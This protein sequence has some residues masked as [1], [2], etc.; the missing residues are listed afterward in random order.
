MR[1]LIDRHPLATTR[2]FSRG[3]LVTAAFAF[4]LTP[5]VAF[6]QLAH[7]QPGGLG[8]YSIG[9]IEMPLGATGGNGVYSWQVVSGT[10]PPGVSLRTDVVPGFAPNQQGELVGIATTPGTYDFTLRV[11]SATEAADQDYTLTISS[12]VAKD[13]Y[14]LP[15]GFA[16]QPYSYALTAIRDGAAVPATWALIGGGVPGLTLTP[17]GTL[18]GRP[19]AAGS[20]T[21]FFSLT[22]GPDRVWRWTNV[23]VNQIGIVTD[24]ALPNATPGT[25][26][27]AIVAASGGSGS[28]RFAANGS[29]PPGLTLDPTGLIFG[30]TN[31]GPGKWSSNITATD[32]M[33]GGVYTKSMSIDV[34]GMPPALPALTPYGYVFDDCTIGIP[35]NRG[36]GVGSGGA[37]PYTW[38]ASGLPKGMSIRFGSGTTSSWVTPGDGEI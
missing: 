6:A 25:P 35:C 15:D 8:M 28:Y 9:R 29:L 36:I 24:G 19:T 17:D 26:Y 10:L 23:N 20:Y 21:I 12:L 7:A 38:T 22:N 27:N 2:P 16:G 1:R 31:V 4:W 5:S 18:T 13:P 3:M 37:A 11:T 32:A 33:T 14:Q 30:T 34:L